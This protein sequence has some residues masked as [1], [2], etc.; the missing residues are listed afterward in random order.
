MLFITNTSVWYSLLL[1]AVKVLWRGEDCWNECLRLLSVAERAL[2]ARVPDSISQD[3]SFFCMDE[4][5]VC[6]RQ[7]AYL[8]LF[9]SYIFLSRLSHFLESSPGLQL[10]IP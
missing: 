4:P 3:S 6:R 1:L 9:A 8:F 10:N 5:I 2:E 7:I